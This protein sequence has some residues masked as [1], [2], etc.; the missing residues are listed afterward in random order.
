MLRGNNFVLDGFEVI[1]N[2]FEDDLINNI[3]KGYGSKL[4]CCVRILTFRYLSNESR[5]EGIQY[6]T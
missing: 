2:N 5:V 1:G 4:V 3:T 6:V